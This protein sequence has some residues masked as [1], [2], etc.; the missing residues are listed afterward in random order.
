M[1]K[2]IAFPEFKNKIVEQF[3]V[4]NKNSYNVESKDWTYVK[5]LYINQDSSSRGHSQTSKE[6]GLTIESVPDIRKK[7]NLQISMRK[8]GEQF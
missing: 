7:M 3:I 6:I 4:Y 2:L 8:K 1:E 5:Q